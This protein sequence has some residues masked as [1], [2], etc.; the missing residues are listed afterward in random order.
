MP[1]VSIDTFFACSLIVSVALLATASFA[2]T[3]QIRINSLQDLNK[4]D[5]LKTIA[6]Q[7]VTHVGTPEDWGSSSSTI[8]ESFGLDSS[9]SPYLYELD[10]DKI[11]RLSSQNNYSLSYFQVSQA[12]RLDNLALGIS[13]SQLLTITTQLSGNDTNGDATTYTFT[14]SV[15]QAQGPINASLHC[16][17]TAKDFL[18][19]VY[20]TT[21]SAGVGAVSVQIPNSSAGPA[22]L[23]VF[24]RASF[25]E[26]L[27]AYGVYSF[28]HLSQEPSPNRTFLGLGPLNYTLNLNPKSPDITIEDS[29]AFSY[30]Y[31]SNLTSTSSTTYAIPAF[32]DKSPIVLVVSGHNDTASFVEWAAYPDIPLEFGA[33]FDNSEKN[34]FVYTISVKDA[35]YKLTLSFGDVTD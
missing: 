19:D 16:Y 26:R 22:L 24:A 5:Y 29:Y 8:P 9:T 2:G 32:L 35:L 1:T 4:D 11:T 17:V 7:I 21:S 12:A 15:S 6:E 25:D 14:I 13:L 20:N 10:I 23:V 28:T 31:Q 30:A 27:T 3:M 18:T 33:N 34:V